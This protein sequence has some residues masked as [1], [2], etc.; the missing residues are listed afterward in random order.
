MN[1]YTELFDILVI[2]V[3]LYMLYMGFSGKGTLYKSEN[4]KKE[5]KEKYNKLIKWF[6]LIGGFIAIATGVFDYI[7]IQPIATI[8]FVILCAV[9][10]SVAVIIVTYTNPKK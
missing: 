3:G 10:I 2:I 1:N 5:M 9:V 6:S 4:I 7:K 8:L